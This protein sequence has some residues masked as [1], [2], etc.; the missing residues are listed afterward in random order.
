[1]RLTGMFSTDRRARDFAHEID[2]HLA[3]HIEDNLRAGMTPDQARRDAMLKLGGLEWT[4][5]AYRERGTIPVVEHVLQDVRFA[6]RQWRKSPAF[7]CTAML[8][9]ALG[10]G[11]SVTIF[12]F[13]DA[14]LIKPLPY[15]DP[16]RL[17]ALFESTPLGP[18]YHLSYLNYVD[19]K[20][21][22]HAFSAVEVYDT[23]GFM[24]STSAGAQQI[25]GAVVTEG[26]FRTLGV[27]PV[28]GRDFRAGEDVPTAPR[29]IMLSYAAWQQRF[30][31]R[32]DVVGQTLTL[33]GAPNTIIGVLPPDFHFAP[34]GPAEIWAAL[35]TSCAEDRGC[36]NLSGLARLQDGVS[37]QTASSDMTV[38]ARQLE[39]QYPDANGDRGATVMPLTDVIVGGIR[40]ILLLLL[41]GAGLLLL[42]ACV[43]VA[44]LLLVRSERRNRE[45]AVRAA[46]GASRARLASQ[47][48][49][50]GM[51]LAAAGGA[52]GVMCAGWAMQLLTRLIPSGMKANM[53]YL[54]GLGLHARVMLFA[55]VVSAIAGVVFSLIP[56]WRLLPSR[57]DLRDG[58]T[59]GSRGSAGTVWRRLGAHLVVIELATAMVLLVGAGLLGQSVYRLLHVDVGLRPDHLAMLRVAA[60]SSRYATEDKQRVL[61][62]QVLDQVASLPGVQSVS[63][64]E[65]PPVG[66]SGGST[67]FS[68]VGKP[69]YG[70]HIQINDRSASAGYFTTLQARLLR[71]RSFTEAEAAAKPPRVV[72]VNQ[73]LARQYFPGEGEDA[74][75]KKVIDDDW[76]DSPLEIIGIV[77]DIKEGP[78]DMTARPV[79]YVPFDQVPSRNFFVIVRTSQ[80]EQSVLLPLAAAIHHLDPDILTSGAVTMSERIQDSPSAYL[81]RSSA[82]LVGGFAAMAWLL[83]VVGLYGVIAYSVSQRRREVGIRMALGAQPRAVYR[84]IL[85]EASRLTAAGI[86]AGVVCAVAGATLMR[87][88][89]FGIDAWDVPTLLS[90]ATVLALSALLASYIPAR[91]AASVN[92][93]DALSAE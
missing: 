62:R 16:T 3:M 46:L 59:E 86:I 30:A 47:F 19:W 55:C 80:A 92:P 91:R 57:A 56:T 2:S 72:I 60:P 93:I 4:K 50:E 48:V 82:W 33:D 28:L 63:I 84:L 74:L 25:H 37:V 85:M 49:T 64:A 79:L 87:K 66:N 90:V 61:A 9:L 81:R 32:D 8:I 39:K 69:S 31:G 15:R 34:A 78:L 51:V 44:S 26:F 40:P 70:A 24:L 12:G 43:N 22:N 23:Q 71:G 27:T 89:L 42:I 18:Q 14:A 10:I 5:Q 77:D 41:S 35:H 83:G 1:V 36:H 75:G 76:P 11:A 6:I 73:A 52:L 68:V 88:L 7:A 21:L 65:R 54:Q 17:V 38:I 20:R 53:P 67:T 45:V 13:V 58:L 29:T